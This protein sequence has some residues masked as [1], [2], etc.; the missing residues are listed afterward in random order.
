MPSPSFRRLY[1]SSENKI[2]S[3]DP[4]TQMGRRSSWI[5][6]SERNA[7]RARWLS[8]E[9]DESDG[10]GEDSAYQ[11]AVKD[12]LNPSRLAALDA[13][14][15]A[16]IPYDTYSFF[17]YILT[18]RGRNFPMMIAPLVTLFIWGLGWQLLFY[19]GEKYDNGHI[20]HLQDYLISLDELIT[21]LL[22]PLSFLMTFRLGRAAVRFWDARAAVGT[23]VAVCRSNISCV[24]VGAIRPIRL[25]RKKYERNQMKVNND[26]DNQQTQQ[27]IGNTEKENREDDEEVLDLLCEYSRW[28][29]VFPIAVKHFIRDS[30]WSR[31]IGDKKR[32]YEIGPLLS[33][34]DATKVIKEY[35]DKKTGEPTSDSSGTRARDPPL[36]VLNRLHELAY[37]I[38]H[39]PYSSNEAG[40]TP[41]SQAVFYQQVIEQL[42]ILCEKYGT[43]ERIKGTPLPFVYA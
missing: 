19:F 13:V 20:I 37:D 28:L 11:K 40:A 5:E 42:N 34:D 9:T 10:E 6:L 7:S 22:T 36:V 29:A 33:D 1:N 39:F 25:R 26:T 32:R 4:S 38:C 41:Q 21:P 18:I 24:C 43:M 31:E 27:S 30:L 2:S 35:D 15:A 3:I 17:S 16:P 12:I 8:M 23:I 14:D